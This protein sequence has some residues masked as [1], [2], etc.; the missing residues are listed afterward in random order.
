MEQQTPVPPTQIKD[1]VAQGEKR[2]I[3]QS[4]IWGGWG[5]GE[6]GLGFPF[7]LSKIILWSQLS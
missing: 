2:A 1:E 7:I 5:G 6:G 3:F 4:L